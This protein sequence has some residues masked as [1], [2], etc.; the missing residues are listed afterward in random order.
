MCVSQRKLGGGVGVAEEE[1]EG[2]EDVFKQD[3]CVRTGCRASAK[4]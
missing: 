1:V 2:V 3:A 4:E